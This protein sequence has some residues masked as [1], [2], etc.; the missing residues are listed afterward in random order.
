MGVSGLLTPRPN[1]RGE[2]ASSAYKAEGRVG[3]SDGLDALENRE[4]CF[5]R[6]SNQNFLVF[7]PLTWSLYRCA[8]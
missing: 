5:C 2:R 1:I 8:K 7:Q 3:P 4:F 6:E